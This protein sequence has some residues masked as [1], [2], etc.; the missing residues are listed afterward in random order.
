MMGS[1][2]YETPNIDQLAQEGIVFTNAYAAASNCAPSRASLLSGK[3]SPRHGIYTVSPSARGDKKTRRLIPT[4]NTKYLSKD[5][6]TIADMFKENGYVTGSFGKWHIGKDPSEHGIDQNVG[7]SGRGNPGR[8]GYFSPYNI[9]FIKDGPDGE[10]LTDRL[11]DEAIAF[12]DQNKEKPFFMYLPYYTVHTPIMAKQELLKKFQNIEG[13][14][15]QN[16]P[17]YAA[18]IYSMDQNVGRLLS[19]LNE[20][21]LESN[22]LIVFTSDNGGI[23]DI[24]TQDPLRAGKGSYYEGGLRVPLIVKHLDHIKSGRSCDIQVSNMDFFPTFKNYINADADMEGLD[25]TDITPLFHGDEIENRD[26]FW[27]FPIYLQAYNPKT[28]DGRDP[29]FRTRPGSVII[30]ENWKLHEYFEDGSLELYDLSRDIGERNNLIDSESD[31]AAALLRKLERWRYQMKAPVPVEKNPFFDAEYE[32]EQILMTA[33][34][35]R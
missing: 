14:P 32:K 12:V 8:N 18:M 27:H 2:Y 5:E 23:R 1:E 10:Y 20:L 17:E 30:S 3:Y 33:T 29:L 26:L 15:G 28:D 35:S 34:E 25:G 21:Q 24:S 9:D 11:T 16:N 13:S 6:Y 7:G 19:R 31:R 22:T 4:P